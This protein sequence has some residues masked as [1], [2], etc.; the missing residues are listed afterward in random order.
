MDLLM[1]WSLCKKPLP[2]TL[3]RSIGIPLPPEHLKH[4]GKHAIDG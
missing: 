2:Q 4:L 3:M 1:L